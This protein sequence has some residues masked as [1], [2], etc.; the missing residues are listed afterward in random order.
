MTSTLLGQIRLR[1][2]DR[3]TTL[4]ILQSPAL[5]DDNAVDSEL[6]E[7]PSKLPH[8]DPGI[9]QRCFNI[10]PIVLTGLVL[11]P[12]VVFAAS[13]MYRL[14]QP[15]DDTIPGAMTHPD[16]KM[17]LVVICKA[18]VDFAIDLAPDLGHSNSH[19]GLEYFIRHG[20]ARNVVRVLKDMASRTSPRPRSYD[21]EKMVQALHQELRA[22][23]PAAESTPS[24]A[25]LGAAQSQ[26]LRLAADYFLFEILAEV[27]LVVVM[28]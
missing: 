4:G 12:P 16:I 10:C 11:S 21:L 8:K 6:P 25:H 24:I 18:P 23:V 7:W 22:K 17:A 20:A 19:G 13:H 3:A 27:T 14:K 5:T 26:S 15:I 2:Q 9:W 28:G 1:L